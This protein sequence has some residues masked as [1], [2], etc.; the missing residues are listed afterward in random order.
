MM[1]RLTL[2]VV[3]VAAAL[4]AAPIQA[5]VLVETG[6][7]TPQKPKDLGDI[8]D[9]G[10]KNPGDKK[11][12]PKTTAVAPSAKSAKPKTLPETFSG[13]TE[14]PMSILGIDADVLTRFS[15]AL[16][17]E[18]KQR[19]ETPALTRIKYEELAAPAGNFTQ[20][21]YWVLKERV[22]PFCEAIAA[23]QPPPDNLTL[24][25]MPS[26]GAAIRPRCP[27]LLSALLLNR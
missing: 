9:K 4:A 1:P 23:T 2:A 20:R 11:P 25:Y 13:E 5:Q 22:R 21:Q 24:S 7:L 14:D 19:A 12:A 6:I 8:W 26:E 15:A 3:L 17:V 16:A 27:E 10:M 18:T